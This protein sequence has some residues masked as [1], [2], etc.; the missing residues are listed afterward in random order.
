MSTPAEGFVF[1]R[2]RVDSPAAEVDTRD[3]T[4]PRVI[5]TI[6]R[7]ATKTARREQRLRKTEH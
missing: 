3:L 6:I 1:G 2:A 5:E 4:D 7:D